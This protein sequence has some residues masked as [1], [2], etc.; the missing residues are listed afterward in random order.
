MKIFMF[1]MNKIFLEKKVK[2]IFL[3]QI[4]KISLIK[5]QLVFEQMLKWN[6]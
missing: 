2:F 1:K 3:T 4:D 5:F 6:V